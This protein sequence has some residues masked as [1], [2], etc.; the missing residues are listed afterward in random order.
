MLNNNSLGLLKK[1]AAK[2]SRIKSI[3]WHA[4][5]L[6]RIRA[7]ISLRQSA[8]VRARTDIRLQSIGLVKSYKD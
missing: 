7:D 8:L 3:V 5:W 2:Q 4:R 1:D 6:V